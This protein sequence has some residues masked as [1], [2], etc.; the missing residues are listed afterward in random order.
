MELLF[1][2]NII[3]AFAGYLLPIPSVILSWRQWLKIRGTPP[4][5]TWRRVVSEVALALVSV[6]LAFWI[7]VVPREV[8]GDYSYS[9]LSASIARWGSSG[10]ILLS[11]FA[12]GRLRFYLLLG[13]VGLFFFFTTSVGDWTI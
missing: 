6:G 1:R 5:K 11:L 13:A 2:L 8:W 7:Y 3:F 12:E 9:L 10:L 4:A